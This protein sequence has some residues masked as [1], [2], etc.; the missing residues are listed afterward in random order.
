MSNKLASA[1]A[2]AR[3]L[4]AA[5]EAAMPRVFSDAK[6]LPFKYRMA[7]AAYEAAMDEYATDPELRAHMVCWM[8]DF[9]GKEEPRWIRSRREPTD[10]EMLD[11]VAG[12]T[13]S[14]AKI[15]SVWLRE[16]GANV[17]DSGS[18]AG[19][20]HLGAHCSDEESRI[21]CVA[22]RG[23]FAAEIASGSLTLSLHFWGW[24]FSDLHTD[25]EGAAS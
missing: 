3:E 1:L 4:Y 2:I 15:V 6:P 23:R 9:R 24:Q 17:T 12:T 7:R 21:L 19:G 14:L 20:W 22:A 8:L 10:A 25:D 13:S 5:K 18:G 11:T 16:Q